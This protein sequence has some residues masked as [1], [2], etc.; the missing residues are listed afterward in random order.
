MKIQVQLLYGNPMYTAPAGSCPMPIT[1]SRAASTIHDRSLYSAFLA[2]E[3]AGSNCGVSSSYVKFDGQHIFAVGSSITRFG[4]SKISA[5]GIRCRNPEEYGH[6]L[7]AFVPAVHD[8][9]PQAK[10]IY[11]G[12]ADPTSASSLQRALTL[13]IAPSQIDVFAYHT[14]PGY[15]QNM[16]PESMDYGA[17]GDE[18]TH[19]IA[20]NGAQLILASDHDI[21]VLGRRVQLHSVLAGIG[22][23]RAIEVYSARHYL[24]LG[25]GVRTFVWLLTAGVDGNEYDD[26]GFIHGLRH[27]PD[28]FTPR[29]VFYALQ[30]TNALFADTQFRCH[31]QDCAR[32]M[33]P[34][35]TTIAAVSGLWFPQ[36]E[37]QA[38]RGLLAGCA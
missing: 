37:R 24:Q 38:Y 6:L 28:D 29:P 36:Q 25:A 12:Q 19:Q 31:H 23:I 22:R 2:S 27:L 14:Y 13:A 16:H 11:G 9:D 32:R 18:S 26:F 30:N 8:T 4:M 15:G 33:S 5:I 34:R 35:C 20:R 17:Y 3:D 21:P 1:P 10:V 7:T